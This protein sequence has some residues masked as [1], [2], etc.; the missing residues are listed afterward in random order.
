M[1]D[2]SMFEG[3]HEVSSLILKITWRSDS[4]YLLIKGGYTMELYDNDYRRGWLGLLPRISSKVARSPS[5]S[6]RVR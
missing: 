6:A 4:F 3:L 5:C 2:G 1:L